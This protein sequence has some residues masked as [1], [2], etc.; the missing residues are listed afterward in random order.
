MAAIQEGEVNFVF[1]FFEFSILHFLRTK[2]IW[3]SSCYLR[4]CF[5]EDVVN[6]LLSE[7]TG[8]KGSWSLSEGREEGCTKSGNSTELVYRV[9]FFFFFGH[10]DETRIFCLVELKRLLSVCSHA[11]FNVESRSASDR[12]FSSNVLLTSK[13]LP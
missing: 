11:F 8:T 5:T 9:F 10:V 1:A 6:F 3:I 13:V 12:K 2:F 7:S 4:F